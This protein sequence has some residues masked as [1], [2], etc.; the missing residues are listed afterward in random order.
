MPTNIQQI[1]DIERGKMILRVEGEMTRTDAELL[2]KIA[3]EMRRE[4]GKNLTID[5]ADLH[6]LDSDGAPV[7]KRMA[8]E[9]GF[10]IEGLLMFLQRAVEE[11]EKRNSN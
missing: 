1:E 7:L 5:L 4:T 9:H 2:E 11:N 6:F 3:L 8:D 10:E